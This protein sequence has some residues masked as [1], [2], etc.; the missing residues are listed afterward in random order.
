[1][2]PHVYQYLPDLMPG[3]GVSG[4]ALL[5]DRIL[6]GMGYQTQIFADHI[7]PE[8]ESRAR[9]RETY[10]DHG[11]NILLIHHAIAQPFHEWF[12]NLHDRRV[13]IYHN[14]SP[15]HFFSEG[16]LQYEISKAGRQQ[17]S[18]WQDKFAGSIAIS[19]YNGLELERLGYQNIHT[20]PLV[21]DLK[22][23]EII[24]ADQK[25]LQQYENTF[26][27]IFVGRIVENKCQHDLIHAFAALDR[28][29]TRLFLLGGTSSPN[30][31][32]Y[33]DTLI[34]GYGLKD[35]IHFTGKVSDEKLWGY[36]QASHLFLCLSEHEGFGIPLIEASFAGIPVVAYGSSNIRSTLGKNGCIIQSKNAREVAAILSQLIENPEMRHRLIKSQQENLKRFHPDNLANMLAMLFGSLGF[37]ME[38]S[39]HSFNP[40]PAETPCRIR[41][42][43]PFDSTYSLALLNREL[44]KAMKKDGYEV[45]L[46]STEGGGDYPPDGRFLESL[47]EI[48]AL[49]KNDKPR[50]RVDIVVRNLYPPRVTGMLGQRN[51]LGPYGWEESGFP[52]P[53]ISAFNQRLHLMASMSGYVTQIL[54]NNGLTVPAATIGIGVDHLINIEAETLPFSFPQGY[55]LLHVSSCFPRKGSD[56]LLEAFQNA[57]PNGKTVTLIIKTFPNPHNRVRE[58]MAAKGWLQTSEYVFSNR[59]EGMLNKTIILVEQDFSAG[60]MVSLYRLGNL[61]IAPS[62]G[63]GFGL[64]LAEAMV[65]DLP[66]L[67]T[68]FGGQMDFCNNDTAWLIDYQFAKAQ[69]HMGLSDSVWVEPVLDDLVEKMNDLAELPEKTIKQK[70]NLAKQSILFH[71]SW[72]KVAERLFRALSALDAQSIPR[73]VP[74]LC[75]VSTWNIRCGIAAYSENLIQALPVPNIL[76]L[77]NYSQEQVKADGPE[78]IR[79]WKPSRQDSLEHL[80]QIMV[81][82]CITDVVFQF[83]FDFFDLSAFQKLLLSLAEK[84]VRSYVFFHSTADVK[85]PHEPKSLSSIKKAL[86]QV[87]KIFVHS[88]HDLNNL[89]RMGIVENVAI[90]PHG[91]K[92][93]SSTA[94]SVSQAPDSKTIAAYGFLLPHKGIRE[95]ISAFEILRDGGHTFDLLLL[96]ALFPTGISDQEYQDISRMI[97]KSPYR[98]AITMI[99]DYLQ[100]DEIHRQL[101]QARIIVYPCQNTQESSSASVRAGI[102]TGR[103]VA[104]TPLEIFSD[105]SDVVYSL[106]GISPEDIAKGILNLMN[107]RAAQARIQIRQKAWLEEHDFNILGKRL[108]HIISSSCIQKDFDQRLALQKDV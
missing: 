45:E 33:L 48:K 3:D 73:P 39:L 38:T 84:G 35:R 61:L 16:S 26:N 105:V 95:L 6:A 18:L 37:E 19:E 57:Y 12:F 65:F 82:R 107:D 15:A 17:L 102:A 54:K 5:I 36:Y 97:E 44:A 41:I 81:G 64:P 106:P 23:F 4:S 50:D 88:V 11:N 49:W 2:T 25:I 10:Q 68:G 71:Y 75:W 94:G 40:R 66:V 46:Y 31:H 108:W 103:P 77:A 101:S 34:S 83:N 76:I 62:R 7:S 27:L 91:V 89:K 72:K 14:I 59:R 67:T 42:E 1:M 60:Q 55:T 85:P 52:Y 32:Q 9:P 51:V 28:P 90:F 47:P 13:M 92:N 22:R 104:V 78:V 70:T 8:F 79:S 58:Q 56:V 74:R 21:V 69:T 63:E 96:N 24:Q 100:E 20:I 43:G 87:E 93:F 53:W 86:C 29:D 30:Y 99:N 80:H 98:Q